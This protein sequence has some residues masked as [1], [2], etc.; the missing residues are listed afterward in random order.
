MNDCCLTTHTHTHTH[1]L[2]DLSRYITLERRAHPY[3]N[4][5]IISDKNYS[6]KS[7]FQN[8]TLRTKT[9]SGLVS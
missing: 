2:L 6:K 5:P 9:A 3:A 1:T 7:S 4:N 8:F